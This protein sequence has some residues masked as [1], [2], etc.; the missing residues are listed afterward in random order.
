MIL[1]PAAILLACVESRA[2]L[3]TKAAI[4]ET[5]ELVQIIQTFPIDGEIVSRPRYAQRNSV[6]RAYTDKVTVPNDN[7]SRASVNY[8]ND[9]GAM[10]MIGTFGPNATVTSY[11][12]AC[13][14]EG[15][16]SNLGWGVRISGRACEQGIRVRSATIASGVLEPPDRYAS[17]SKAFE[18][19][20]LFSPNEMVRYCGAISDSGSGWEFSI[21]QEDWIDIFSPNASPCG[22][23]IQLCESITNDGCSAATQGEWALSEPILTAS[24]RCDRDRSFTRRNVSGSQVA[25]SLRALER[26]AISD[27]QLSDGED[28]ANAINCAPTVIAANEIVAQPYGIEAT[29]IQATTTTTTIVVDT[30][31]GAVIIRSADD[32]DGKLLLKGE[33]YLYDIPSQTGAIVP[34][35][36]PRRQAIAPD[37]NPGPFNC[38]QFQ[39]PGDSE[40]DEFA[41]ICNQVNTAQVES[42]WQGI[43]IAPQQFQVS[44]KQI[45]AEAPPYGSVQIPPDWAEYGPESDGS[46]IGTQDRLSAPRSTLTQRRGF[47]YDFIAYNDSPTSTG[48]NRPGN[49]QLVY[50]TT[51]SLE[52]FET[53]LTLE[54]LAAQLQQRGQ[55]IS[56]NPALEFAGYDTIRHINLADGEGLETVAVTTFDGVAVEVMTYYLIHEDEL[57]VMIMETYGDQFQQE[58]DEL[59]LRKIAQSFRLISGEFVTPAQ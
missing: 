9:R 4:S 59:T 46:I 34:F 20:N 42:P 7:R 35:D 49:T 15:G 37:T 16:R 21:S 8:Y 14:V 31:S 53:R 27:L 1:V 11:I 45:T 44:Q 57:Y 41:E 10:G 13:I 6:V 43:F 29:Q 19:G 30:L 12:F 52:A 47:S 3:P 22:E 56:G 23:A 32:P 2:S 38:D 58:S 55:P 5:D 51:T 48:I 40:A 28:A 17:L 25:A 36:D 50:I 39:I 18:L 54:E 33:S 26:E 24:L